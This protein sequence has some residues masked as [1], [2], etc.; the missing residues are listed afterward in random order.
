MGKPAA[1]GNPALT[2]AVLLIFWYDIALLGKNPA[3]ISYQLALRRG[4]QM[5]SLGLQSVS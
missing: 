4:P 3:F 2:Y 1:A 5:H